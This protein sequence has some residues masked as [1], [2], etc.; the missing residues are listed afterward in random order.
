V[1]FFVLFNKMSTLFTP[2]RDSFPDGKEYSE[3]A[4]TDLKNVSMLPDTLYGSLHVLIGIASAETRGVHTD[5]TDMTGACV[6]DVGSVEDL[7][8]STNV[9]RDCVTQVVAPL[10]TWVPLFQDVDMI[11]PAHPDFQPTVDAVL[12]AYVDFS[13]SPE[14]KNMESFLKRD[15]AEKQMLKGGAGAGAEA[16]AEGEGEGEGEAEYMRPNIFSKVKHNDFMTKYGI[17]V[18]VPD[19]RKDGGVLV[20]LI[21]VMGGDVSKDE[22]INKVKNYMGLNMCT[23]IISVVRNREWMYPQYAHLR[24]LGVN[25]ELAFKNPVLDRV[26]RNRRAAQMRMNGGESLVSLIKKHA[27]SEG[28]A[29]GAPDGGGDAEVSG[30]EGGP[31]GGSSKV[32]PGGEAGAGGGDGGGAG[33]GGGDEDV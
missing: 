12:Q 29:D 8:I 9:M 11:T 33:G 6:I 13:N 18:C 2:N 23:H 19:M 3:I 1:F 16:G 17:L 26:V 32:A 14:T 24:F 21:A 31:A 10:C 7:K 27:E 15:A 5:N 30:D 20:P 22:S 25:E 28:E 4:D